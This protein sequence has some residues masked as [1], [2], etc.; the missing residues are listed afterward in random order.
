M[1]LNVVLFYC[2]PCFIN[3]AAVN[4]ST[5]LLSIQNRRGCRTGPQTVEF[6]YH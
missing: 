3:F 6:D 1:R 5:A 4:L 2:V